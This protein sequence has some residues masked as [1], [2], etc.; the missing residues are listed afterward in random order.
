M[1]VLVTHI[2]KSGQRSLFWSEEEI[3]GIPFWN[4]DFEVMENIQKEIS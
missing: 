4:K 1:M 2:G 3:T